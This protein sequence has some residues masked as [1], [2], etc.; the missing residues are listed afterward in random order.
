MFL[1]KPG[2]DKQ[3]Y[4]LLINGLK[5]D[6]MSLLFFFVRLQYEKTILFLIYYC[7]K[8]AFAFYLHSYCNNKWM[9]SIYLGNV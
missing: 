4:T 9:R 5:I 6:F 7:G 1:T 2:K 8:F 3:Q